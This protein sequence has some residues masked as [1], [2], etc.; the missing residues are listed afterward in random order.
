MASPDKV[1]QIFSNGTN[2][3]K[4]K[5]VVNDMESDFSSVVAGAWTNTSASGNGFYLG[6]NGFN[7]GLYSYT[8]I[9][10]T[11]SSLEGCNNFIDGLTVLDGT[12]LYNAVGKSIDDLSVILL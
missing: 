6:M 11:N 2:Y 12:R 4:V 1:L 3:Y 8:I 10:I 9:F 7:N 5:A